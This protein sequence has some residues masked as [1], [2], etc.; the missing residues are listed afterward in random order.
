[1]IVCVVSTN[2]P[3]HSHTYT[4]IYMRIYTRIN[5]SIERR[6]KIY[7]FW[8]VFSCFFRAL[9]RVARRTR[10]LDEKI[11]VFYC[12]IEFS[13]VFFFF[14]EF[15]AFLDD[16]LGQI[17][18][19]NWNYRTF[20]ERKVILTTRTFGFWENLLFGIYRLGI[21]RKFDF[22]HTIVSTK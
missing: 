22:L 13:R 1:M 3:S 2:N 19:E 21:S 4:F 9:D 14:S 15:L 5:G 16:F 10:F 20:L 18:I 6:R 7:G 17:C 11:P 12:K 8:K